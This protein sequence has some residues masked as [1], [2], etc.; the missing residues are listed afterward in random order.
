MPV[1]PTRFAVATVAIDLPLETPLPDFTANP[2]RRER[3]LPEGAVS[4]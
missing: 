1:M 2:R 3:K 4:G